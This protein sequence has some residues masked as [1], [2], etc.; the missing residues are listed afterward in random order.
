MKTSEKL[1]FSIENFLIKTFL[2]SQLDDWIS[3]SNNI[4]GIYKYKRDN[5]IIELVVESKKILF[6]KKVS[7]K[8]EFGKKYNNF[9]FKKIQIYNYNIFQL[10]KYYKFY[11]KTNSIIS[12]IKEE[13][14][15]SKYS[16]LNELMPVA[17]RRKQKLQ[18]I[19]G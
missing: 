6:F 4:K 11:K 3:L 9:Y 10:I 19:K 2:E 15:I 8:F 1:K 18:E 17:D 12:H 5:V 16:E 7:I 13:E 14:L